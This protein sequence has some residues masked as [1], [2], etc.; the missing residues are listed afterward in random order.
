MTAPRTTLPSPATATTPQTPP[1]KSLQSARRP[2]SARQFAPWSAHALLAGWRPAWQSL[3]APPAPSPLHRPGSAPPAS[4]TARRQRTA[5]SKSSDTAA[6]PRRS[7][8]RRP[9]PRCAAAS[10]RTSYP[11]PH[12]CP[13]DPRS[14]KTGVRRPGSPPPPARPAR[15]RSAAALA[16]PRS[17]SPSP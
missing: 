10:A 13:A 11:S 8:C 6:R 12:A 17:E 9:R 7:V 15:A 4:L 3:S 16:P 2:W 1:A 5:G 14:G